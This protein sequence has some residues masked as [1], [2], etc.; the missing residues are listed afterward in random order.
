ML[1]PNIFQWFA[2]YLKR[3]DWK[4]STSAE[5]N[6]SPVVIFSLPDGRKLTAEELKG[7]TGRANIREGKLLAVTGNVQ[8]EIIGEGSVPDEAAFLHRQG[9]Q[10]GG[11]GDYKTALE[12][13]EKASR[14]APQWPY[15]IYD[16]AYTHLLLSDHDGARTYY[17]KTV[18]L[19]PRGFFTAITALDTLTRE[20][21]G[22]LPAGT[23]AAYLSLESV[24]E[25]TKKAE[26]LRLLLSQVAA[27]APAW[28]DLASITE[29]DAERLAFIEKG[30]AAQPDAET[31]G[32]LQINKALVVNLTGNHDAAVRLLGELALDP[33]STLA[34]EFSAKAALS[35]L[36]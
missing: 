19:S 5:S 15:P 14:I 4:N 35:L 6:T 29:D 11:R 8:Y 21:S 2:R 31:K 34:T 18:E 24:D 32:L 25:D 12:L 9:R 1:N 13:L 36:F 30:L 16:I 28:K 22:D 33:S 20:K 17:R 26:T 23:Y 3:E 10:A 7:L 27:F